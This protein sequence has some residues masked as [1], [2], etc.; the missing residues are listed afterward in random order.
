MPV[1]VAGEGEPAGAVAVAPARE[2]F[3]MKALRILGGR[4]L[5][6]LP[7]AGFGKLTDLNIPSACLATAERWSWER[8][9]GLLH[10]LAALLGTGSSM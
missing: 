9:S 6:R 5:E 2:L 3:P 4:L 7:V 8:F 10:R 1:A